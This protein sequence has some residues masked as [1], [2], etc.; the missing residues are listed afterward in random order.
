MRYF[1]F[2][3]PGIP[4][5]FLFVFV[6]I[7]FSALS[8]AV[9]RFL[10]GFRLF[11]VQS[12]YRL[13]GFFFDSLLSYVKDPFLFSRCHALRTQPP[14][15]AREP[16]RRIYYLV[17]PSTTFSSFQLSCGHLCVYID[18]VYEVSSISDATCSAYQ[19][20]LIRIV[21]TLISLFSNF[22]LP[23]LQHL[24]INTAFVRGCYYI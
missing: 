4:F 17:F 6:P 21:R 22:C 11:P 10:R 13:D 12:T 20:H 9:L 7:S 8:P 1:P 3:L 19:M 23:Y 24:N 15:A 14:R 2:C 16:A 18:V 5:P